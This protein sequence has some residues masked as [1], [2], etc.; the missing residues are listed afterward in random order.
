MHRSANAPNVSFRRSTPP[1]LTISELEH[2]AE[3]CE[4]FSDDIM[5]YFFDLDPDSDFRPTWPKII[6][7]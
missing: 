6:R 7:I 2:D 5:L 4:R 1:I 3:K